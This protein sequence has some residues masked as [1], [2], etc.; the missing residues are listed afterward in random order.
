MYYG[1]IYHGLKCKRQTLEV[2]QAGDVEEKDH[3]YGIDNKQVDNEERLGNPLSSPI[4]LP[5]ISH[6]SSPEDLYYMSARSLQISHTPTVGSFPP[7]K[8]PDAEHHGASEPLLGQARST[9]SAP[10]AKTKTMLCVVSLMTF[11][12][13][14]LNL[15]QAETSR[16]NMILLNSTSGVVLQVGRQLLQVTGDFEQET[17]VSKRREIGSIL[18]WGMAAIYLGGRL[19]QICLNGL[20]PLMFVFA[21]VGNATY[22]AS[23]IVSSLKWSKIRPN[24][25]WLVD[26]GGCVLLDT[27]IMIQFIYYR[28]RSSRDVE[29]K[30]GSSGS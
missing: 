9:Q 7:Q 24:L 2:I 26:S 21:I 28:Y 10:P 17:S 14:G 6:D 29:K 19:P 27:F 11:F 8:T 1:H 5:A 3:R 18:G 22:L 20:N 23:I 12:I 15:Q 4:P 16:H 13:G 25:P 30:Y